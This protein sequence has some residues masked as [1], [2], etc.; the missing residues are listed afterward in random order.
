M[1]WA[2]TDN[3]IP[4]ENP[5]FQAIVCGLVFNCP[6]S[7]EKNEKI[8]VNNKGKPLYKRFYKPVSA[9]NVS[10]R[11]RGIHKDLFLTILD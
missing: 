7:I 2:N 10:F 1:K 11:S 9:R 3:L 6:S 8:G 4:I 5:M